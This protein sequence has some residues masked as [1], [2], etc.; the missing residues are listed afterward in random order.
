MNLAR[1]VLILILT[2]GCLVTVFAAK[3]WR[4]N[5]KNAEE[6]PFLFVTGVVPG[7]ISSQ[8]GIKEGDILRSYNGIGVQSIDELEAAKQAAVDSAEVIFDRGEEALSFVFPVGP[9]GVFLKQKLPELKFDEDAVV[10]QGILPLVSE[11]A[12]NNSFILSLTRASNF[13]KD[14]LDYITI[15]GLSGS[16][17]RLQLHRKWAPSAMLASEGYR[18]DTMALN[19]L[20][21]E[22]QYLKLN[23]GMSNMESMRQAIIIN[24]D[25]GSPVLGFNLNGDSTWGIIVG[26][27]KHGREIIVR[28]YNSK[29][30]GYSIAEIFPQQ[31]YLLEGRTIPPTLRE[32]IIKSFAIAQDI[33]ESKPVCAYKCGVDA[34]NGWQQL[35][36]TSD[37]YSIPRDEFNRIVETNYLM[38][39]QLAEDRGFAAEYLKSIVSE[40][41]DI[42]DKLMALI[43][44]YEAEAEHL[45]EGIEQHNVIFHAKNFKTQYDWTPQMRI[46]ETS[47]LRF[48]KIKEEEALKIW[49]EINLIYNPEPLENE[50]DVVAP[51]GE[52]NPE[53]ADTSSTKKPEPKSPDMPEGAQ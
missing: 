50:E 32:A 21:Y 5:K 20:G 44:L 2:A 24:L 33:L 8:L 39:V 3:P 35:L 40:F 52:V 29:R 6:E 53:S 11:D 48:A 17:F 14:T 31:V 41:S 28:T 30:D 7:S 15:M 42:S 4:R 27:Q 47:Y 43:K 1:K 46:K 25:A 51:E 13:L 36:E 38:F 16:A 37:F 19:A 49:R 12:M 10:L 34:L 18:T 9:M 23:E 45:N 22:Y 26:Y